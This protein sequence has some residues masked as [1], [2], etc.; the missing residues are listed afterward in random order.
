MGLGAMV[1]VVYVVYVGYVW[2]PMVRGGMG[3]VG[4]DGAW[5]H[6]L[7]GIRWGVEAWDVWDPMGHGG[8]H[9]GR[10]TGWDFEVES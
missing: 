6:G 1:Y 4:S 3:C 7:C 2:D 10:D 9:L 5:R 8:I